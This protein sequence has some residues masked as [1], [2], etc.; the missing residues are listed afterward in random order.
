MATVYLAEACQQVDWSKVSD[1]VS[2][3]VV[4]VAVCFAIAWVFVTAIRHDR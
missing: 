3:A 2:S 4:G 1:N